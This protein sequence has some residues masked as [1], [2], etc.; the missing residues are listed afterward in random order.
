MVLSSIKAEYIA[1]ILAAKKA[2]W[3][4]LLL[5]KLG[6]LQP[7]EQY[8]LIKILEQNTYAQAIYQDL[9]WDNACG[10]EEKPITE[11][12]ISITISFKGDNQGSIT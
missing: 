11:P 4:Q 6:L 7:E 8:T 5:T 3:L 10:R 1:L 2:T 9:D 12:A